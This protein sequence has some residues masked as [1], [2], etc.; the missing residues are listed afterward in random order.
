M[1]NLHLPCFLSLYILHA[2]GR[3]LFPATGYLFLVWETLASL[4]GKLSADTKVSFD[5]VRF[6]R[7]TTISRDGSVEF[8]VSIHK[9]NG[10][11]EVVEGETSVVGGT[12]RIEDDVLKEHYNM[13]I[14]QVVKDDEIWPRETDVYKELRLRG[15]QYR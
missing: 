13:N 2:S 1:T 5:G 11:F 14:E 9:G 6:N 10:L 15:Y 8:L 7:A 4:N 3:N 12:V